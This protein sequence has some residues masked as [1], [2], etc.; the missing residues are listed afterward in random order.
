M[1]LILSMVSR[2][3]F[4]AATLIRPLIINHMTTTHH[5]RKQKLIWDLAPQLEVAVQLH[6]YHLHVVFIRSGLKPPPGSCKAAMKIT[7]DNS[8]WYSADKQT[9]SCF[10]FVFCNPFC[11]WTSACTNSI[12]HAFSALKQKLFSNEFYK[13]IKQLNNYRKYTKMNNS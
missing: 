3:S 11:V 8:V 5:G 9:D 2:L 7:G 10:I 6:G 1:S 12:N 4:R 13:G